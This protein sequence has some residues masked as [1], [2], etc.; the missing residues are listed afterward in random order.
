M[1]VTPG[2]DHCIFG[3]N[4]QTGERNWIFLN[5]LGVSFLS[6][7]VMLGDVMYQVTGRVMALD[8]NTGKLIGISAENQTDDGILAYDPDNKLIW[9]ATGTGVIRGYK[10]VTP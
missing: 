9:Q 6:K 4:K 1:V 2:S 10:P 7:P 3:V 8:T 5:P